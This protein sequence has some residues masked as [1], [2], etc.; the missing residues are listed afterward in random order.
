MFWSKGADKDNDNDGYCVWL[1]LVLA[2][3]FVSWVKAQ[4]WNSFLLLYGWFMKLWTDHLDPPDLP[5]QRCYSDWG[6][7][8]SGWPTVLANDRN[9]GRPWLNASRHDDDDDNCNKDE[10]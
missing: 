3:L 8:A 2:Y 5:W 1:F 10:L 9:G 6:P 4:L 7:A